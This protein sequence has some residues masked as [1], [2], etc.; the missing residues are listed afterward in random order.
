[1]PQDSKKDFSSDARFKAD[2]KNL[3][4]RSVRSG[5]I[6][7]TDQLFTAGISMASVVVLARLLTP[8]DYGIVAMVTAITGFVNLFRELGLSGATIQTRNITHDQVSSLFWINVGLGAVITLIIAASGPILSWFYHKPQLTLVAAG[9]SLTSVLS[10]LGTQH[11]ALLNR[12]MRFGAMAVIRISS[13][14]AG[15]L[16]ALVVALAGGTYWS[17]VSSSVVTALWNTCGLWIASG[18]RP[19]RPKK[20]TG[21]RP[22]MRF[23]ANLAGFDIVNYFHRNMDNILI[24]RVWGAEQLGLYHKAYSLLMLPISSLR[25][26][27]NRVAFPA[28]SQLQNEPGPFRSYFVK[29]C[30]LL[31][32]IT[33]P[34]VV[35]LFVCSEHVIR[36]L[37]G[38]RWVGASELFSILAL[39]SFIQPTAGLRG[40]VLLALGKGGRFFRWGL[41][42]AIVTVASFFCGLPWGAKGVA[43]AY[44]IS[45]YLILHP[46]LVYSFRDTPIRPVDFYRSLTRPMFASI[47]MG[48]VLTLAEGRLRGLSDALILALLFLLGGLIYLGVLFLLPGGRPALISYWGYLAILRKGA[49]EMVSRVLGRGSPELSTK[50]PSQSSDKDDDNQ[51]HPCGGR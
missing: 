24:G 3:K 27:L 25:Y 42:I 30:A 35:F 11:G 22:L 31:S 4:E 23:G 1:M 6:T 50:S 44:C 8:E 15:F 20:G 40:T 10:S 28:L 21:V 33:M 43:I 26:P 49:W 32:F 41:Y 38:P 45:T 16:V 7:L 2:P 12:Q 13:V 39:V 47:I 48:V 46:S 14:L 17:L 51:S 5:A 37:L 9:I 19:G 36:L 29:Y 18:F 34:I